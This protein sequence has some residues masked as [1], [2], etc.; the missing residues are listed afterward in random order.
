MKPRTDEISRI[1]PLPRGLHVA[2]G[3]LGEVDQGD[4][5]DLDD[6]A[7]GF[8]VLGFEL[9]VVSQAGVVDEQVEASGHGLGLFPEGLAEAWSARS[10]AEI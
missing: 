2:D 1:W 6:L 10:P 8:G 4:Q 3:L 9:G 5:V 7:D